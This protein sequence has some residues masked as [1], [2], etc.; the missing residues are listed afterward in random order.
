MVI[1]VEQGKGKKDRNGC[2]RG[3][4]SCCGSG[5]WLDGRDVAVP[6]PR[7]A[8]ADHIAPARAVRATNAIISKLTV[9]FDI[10]Q[11]RFVRRFV[12]EGSETERAAL[13]EAMRKLATDAGMDLEEWLVSAVVRAPDLLPDAAPSA[14]QGMITAI[15]A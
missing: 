1:R 8:T 12:Y 13:K 5:G 6:W 4:W 11:P 3:C 7:S 2:H 9:R 15:T 10:G 14:R